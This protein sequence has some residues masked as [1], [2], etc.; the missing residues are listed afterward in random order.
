MSN[1]TA[2]AV[3][4]ESADVVAS[5]RYLMD[6]AHSQGRD[7]DMVVVLIRESADTLKKR[8]PRGGGLSAEQARYLVESGAFD[9]DELAETE[10]EVAEG[11]LATA[12][13]RTRIS[14]LTRTLSA[15]EIADRLGLDASSVRH[16]QGKGLLYGFLVGGKRRYP[17][18]QLV[19]DTNLSLPRLAAVVEAF[20]EDWHPAT[21]EG[22]MTTPQENLRIGDA[23]AT[24]VE[25]LLND[26]DPRKIVGI[27]GSFLQS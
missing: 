26:G 17:T 27:L 21:I 7:D 19:G 16:R 12:E 20:P 11:A 24:P 3:V 8:Q 2:Q 1:A 6:A 23:S 9:A 10:R 22:F 18:W 13:R 5:V 4:P 15:G 14:T 25:W